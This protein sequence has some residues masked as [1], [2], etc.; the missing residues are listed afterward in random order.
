MPLRIL[1]NYLKLLFFLSILSGNS[2]LAEEP[3]PS[4]NEPAPRAFLGI[5]IANGR[6]TGGPVEGVVIA[7]V[8]PGG[9]ASA[10]GLQVDDVIVQIGEASL[11]AASESEANQKLLAFMADVQ[12]DDE[13]KVIYLRDGRAEHLTVTADELDPTMITEPGLPFIRDL[14]R[15]SRQF[16]EDFI[17]PLKYRWRHHGLF[18]GMELVAVTPQLGRYFGTDQGLL[19]VRGPD[20]ENIDLQDGDVI[21]EIGGRVPQDPDHAMRI[22]R[23]Y[24]A[25]EE[26]TIRIMRNQLENDVEFQF[27]ED[28]PDAEEDAEAG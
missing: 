28:A 6:E 21:R 13:L 17:E 15:L 10:A 24:E 14:E 9:A 4:L 12:P 5:N 22:L 11:M 23:S 26:V 1:N 7:G 3:S 8:T 16:G 19:V 27:P 18:A 20:D 2:V 25:G